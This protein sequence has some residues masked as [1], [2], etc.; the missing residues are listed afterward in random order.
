MRVLISGSRSISDEQ[1]VWDT[2][3]AANFNITSIVVGDARGVDRIARCWALAN[4]IP[5]YM[6]TADWTRYGKRAGFVRNEEMLASG[7]DGVLVIWD[8][9]S[10][11]TKHMFQ[12]ALGVPQLPVIC[13][14]VGG[15]LGN[16]FVAHVECETCP[17]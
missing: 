7:V 14:T 6:Y 10:H 12:S 3:E 15:A 4:K 16:L 11:G 2:I 9:K 17:F 1:F 5:A 13:V 8:G